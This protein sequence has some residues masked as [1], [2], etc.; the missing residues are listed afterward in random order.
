MRKKSVK[1]LKKKAWTF[2]S[3]YIRTKF[4]D[5]H[6]GMVPCVTCG[7]EKNWREQQAGHFISGRG[8]SILFDERGVFPQCYV[9][10]CHK[11]G[12]VLEYIDF[13]RKHYG[14][15]GDEIMSELRILSKKPKSFTVDELETLIKTF[16]EATPKWFKE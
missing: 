3:R 2:F 11:H 5:K 14:I 1:S 6:T 16:D 9:C 15:A 8:N 4:A 12:A 10:N 7:V 13:M